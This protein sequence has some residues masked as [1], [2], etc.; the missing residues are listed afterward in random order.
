MD[1]S[2]RN[3]NSSKSQALYGWAP[4]SLMWASQVS[5]AIWMSLLAAQ[6]F[7]RN[8][9]I[10]SLCGCIYTDFAGRDVQCT[11]LCCTVQYYIQ[12][13]FLAH[14]RRTWSCSPLGLSQ[15]LYPW[16]SSGPVEKAS[17]QPGP[18]QPVQAVRPG[19]LPHSAVLGYSW[20][21]NQNKENG[22]SININFNILWE[23]YLKTFLFS[24][25]KFYSRTIMMIGKLMMT[26][27]MMMIRKKMTSQVMMKIL[28]FWM[29]L[30]HIKKLIFG[31][32]S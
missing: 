7:Q 15:L 3:L 28:T 25:Y 32:I 1:G 30:A 21:H 11:V 10:G 18:G 19:H 17:S 27:V 6:E 13:S 22:C 24:S 26:L 29:I 16:A 5:S 20:Q 2:P 9:G 12:S 31:S 4:R 23:F 14:G 8:W